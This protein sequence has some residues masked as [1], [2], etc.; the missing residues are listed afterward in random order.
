MNKFLK[1]SLIIL[2]V[3]LLAST[4]LMGWYIYSNWGKLTNSNTITNNNTNNSSTTY[5]PLGKDLYKQIPLTERITQE[6]DEEKAMIKFVNDFYKVRIS[7][8]QTQSYA[9]MDTTLR[10][11]IKNKTAST[12]GME[13]NIANNWKFISSNYKSKEII[14]NKITYSE[15]VLYMD[16]LI[17]ITTSDNKTVDEL[18]SVTGEDDLGKQRIT[19]IYYLFKGADIIKYY[20]LLHLVIGRAD[21]NNTSI[22]ITSNKF[23]TGCS[24]YSGSKCQQF[25]YDKNEMTFLTTMS[26]FG[27]GT[28]I[29]LKNRVF[30][31]EVLFGD[32]SVFSQRIIGIDIDTLKSAVVKGIRGNMDL[33][34]PDIEKVVSDKCKAAKLTNAA[35]VAITKNDKDIS[36]ISCYGLD[37]DS[38]FNFKT[39]RIF[40]VVDKKILKELTLSTSQKNSTDG[41]F[42]TY[43]PTKDTAPDSIYQFKILGVTYTVDTS[44]STVTQN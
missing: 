12:S 21:D 1:V 30:T 13:D 16:F 42:V 32:G 29:S 20:D 44:K 38:S 39:R 36:L 18:V 34:V 4:G 8:N 7:Q 3:F 24:G 10:D 22:L 41:D 19:D 33:N 26:D 6:T 9:Y 17:R 43:D 25:K 35:E 11:D 28:P 31:S 23:Y 2:I 27:Y 15:G 14:A 37:K 5:Y 40:V